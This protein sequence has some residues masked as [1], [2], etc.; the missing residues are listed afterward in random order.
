VDKLKKIIGLSLFANVGVAEALF[1][2]ISV[3]IK[4]GN[5]IDEKRARFYSE[6]Y[7]DVQ[8]ICGDIP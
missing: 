3:E 7:P 4:V 1:S 8:M 5:E 2:D 6:V